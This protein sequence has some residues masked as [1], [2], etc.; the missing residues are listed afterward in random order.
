MEPA[1]SFAS[2]ITLGLSW[3]VVYICDVLYGFLLV[4]RISAYKQ[5][6]Y[7]ADIMLWSI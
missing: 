1:N 7:L 6:D 3:P 5:V 2:F 4:I